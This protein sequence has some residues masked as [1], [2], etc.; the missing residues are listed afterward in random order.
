[1]VLEVSRMAEVEMTFQESCDL[2]EI[3]R[4]GRNLV[5]W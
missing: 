2:E 1:M 4:Y 3:L 5:T